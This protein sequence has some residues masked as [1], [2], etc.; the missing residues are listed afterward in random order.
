[1]NECEKCPQ[2]M[3]LQG[4]F[5]ECKAIGAISFLKTEK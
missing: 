2:R 5:L 4:H 3:N 1:M